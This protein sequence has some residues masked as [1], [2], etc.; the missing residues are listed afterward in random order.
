[1]S[2]LRPT[3]A[4]L[5]AE[6]QQDIAT[7]LPTSVPW[8]AR[9]LLRG[10]AAMT[11]GAADIVHAAVERVIRQIWVHTCDDAYVPDHAAEVG[12][13]RTAATKATLT[14]TI[15]GTNTTVIPDETEVVRLDGTAY[16]TL[17]EVTITG[18]TA[19]VSARAVVAGVAGNA[20]AG[21]EVFLGTP[22]A[23]VDE[24]T[25]DAMNELGTDEES[26]ATLR[27]RTWLRKRQQPQGG[28]DADYIAWVLEAVPEAV[29][30][31]VEPNSPLPGDVA[32][33]FIIDG[34]GSAIL[35]GSGL[36]SGAQ[37][38]VDTK[39]PTTAYVTVAAP[40]AETVAPQISIT[41][42]TTALRTATTAALNAMAVEYAGEDVPLSAWWV[43][44]G[45]VAGITSFVLTVPAG[46]TSVA[47]GKTLV[48]GTPVY[49]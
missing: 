24:I 35:P 33:F 9:S 7:S 8:L 4:E 25:V 42:D 18:G 6:T 31:W 2:W 46:L 15:T 23:G 13:T 5:L 45:G 28:A 39:R 40:T 37:A 21:E 36:V 44:I 49:T 1:M 38:V 30:V 26:L 11:A 12:L 32:V 47:A 34:E 27:A 29:A 14:L 3:R 41:P 22:I 19:S 20:G 43:A 17:S 10:L 48:I 16:E